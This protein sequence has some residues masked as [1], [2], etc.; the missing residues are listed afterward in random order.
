MMTRLFLLSHWQSVIV[1]V[2]KLLTYIA[3][4]AAEFMAVP[5]SFSNVC[6][7]WFR[8][9]CITGCAVAS[10]P[11]ITATWLVAE[12][13]TL[14]YRFHTPRPILKNLS[15]TI[16]SATPIP[17]SDLLK[18]M[19]LMCKWNT[20]NLYVFVFFLW[21]ED[22]SENTVFSERAVIIVTLID[23]TLISCWRGWE[24]DATE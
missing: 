4:V 5:F 8:H 17:V 20:T 13:L 16:T 21:T 6:I 19:G 23:I 2:H 9:N 3:R 14:L 10:S 7:P 12:L 24:D 15:D 1:C 11:V 22:V 18:C